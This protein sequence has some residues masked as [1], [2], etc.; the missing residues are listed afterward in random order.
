VTDPGKKSK[1]GRLA[2]V[3]QEGGEY[4]TVQVA[5]CGGA[6]QPEDELVVVF[7]NGV[8]KQDWTFQEVRARAEQSRVKN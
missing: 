6:D 1:R 4:R 7:E 8:L 5:A 2:L 3:K